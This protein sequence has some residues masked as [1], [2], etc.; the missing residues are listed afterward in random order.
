MNIAITAGL[1]LM[2][3]GF[4]AGLS[5]WSRE[6]GTPGSATWGWWLRTSWPTVPSG[7]TQP[8]THWPPPRWA[9]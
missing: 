7:W 4:A 1:Q 9:R 5:A 6:Y 3:P 8:P 2:P